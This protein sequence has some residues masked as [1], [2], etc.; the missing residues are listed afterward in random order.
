[1]SSKKRVTRL[2]QVVDVRK[3]VIIVKSVNNVTSYLSK[4]IFLYFNN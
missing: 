3:K 2:R 4:I 1:M